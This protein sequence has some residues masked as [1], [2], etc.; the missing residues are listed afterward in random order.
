ML[1]FKL[2]QL[3]HIVMS[4]DA[5]LIQAAKCLRSMNVSERVWLS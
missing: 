2:P 5:C 4:Q 3:R 1:N